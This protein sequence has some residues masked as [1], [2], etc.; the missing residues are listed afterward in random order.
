MNNKT[1]IHQYLLELISKSQKCNN[2]HENQN[3]KC[4]FAYMCIKNDFSHYY[5]KDYSKE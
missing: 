5:Q 3:G 4:I 2:C 1:D